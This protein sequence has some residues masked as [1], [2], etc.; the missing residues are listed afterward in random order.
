MY[1]V[2]FGIPLIARCCSTQ[3]GCVKIIDV[4]CGDISSIRVSHN[5]DSTCHLVV[6]VALGTSSF[7]NSLIECINLS[8][9]VPYEIL[10]DNSHGVG[11]RRLDSTHVKQSYATGSRSHCYSRKSL[12][13]S[14]LTPSQL[15]LWEMPTG[16]QVTSISTIK[17]G[18][19]GDTFYRI[20]LL[21]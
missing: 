9:E 19:I 20:S 4:R 12:C 13:N 5:I 2:A 11:F 7:L 18:T 14:C 8:F 16:L 15:D 1:K 6:W 17:I 21:P 3:P 10:L